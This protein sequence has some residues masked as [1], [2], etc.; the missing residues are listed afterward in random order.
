MDVEH[1]YWSSEQDTHTATLSYIFYNNRLDIP[2][3]ISFLKWPKRC[4][5][6]KNSDG[7]P[8]IPILDIR[9]KDWDWHKEKE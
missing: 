8:Y 2:L 5:L 9:E 3:L 6:P 4:N 1:Y 7:E